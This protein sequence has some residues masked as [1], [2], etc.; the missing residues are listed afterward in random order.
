[1][2]KR[3]TKSKG[4]NNEKVMSFW[5]HLEELRGHIIRSLIAVV[6]LAIV[7][8]LNRHLVFDTIILAP[9]TSHFITYQLLCELGNFIH[10]PSLCIK[11][12]NLKIIN[13]NLSGQFLMH[14]Y[15]SAVVGVIV[16]FPYVLW[17]I[18]RF[19]TPAMYSKEKKYSRGGLFFSTFLFLTGVVFSY[20]FI[21]PIM[22]N[23]LGSYS[24]SADVVN[25]ITLNS[26]IS[27]MTSMLFAVGI[28]FELPILVYFLTRIGIVTPHFLKAS[29]KYMV[30]ILLTVAAII[31]P[32]DVFSQM[33]VFIPLEILYEV[34]ILVSKRV[35]KKLQKRAL[36]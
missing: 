7:A 13:I 5:E 20:F 8:F 30:V 33:L 25:Q 2:E 3:T 32:P 26:Y 21:V 27:T 16:A 1:M 23:F 22:V 4:E 31:T 12:V 19:V 24:V 9:S 18:W 11:G 14:M 29:R 17:E 6:I 28:V 36:E 10:A 35:Y 34:S 15:I